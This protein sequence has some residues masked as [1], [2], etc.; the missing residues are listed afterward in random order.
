[1]L[2]TEHKPT[3]I[4]SLDVEATG[5]SPATSSCVMIG[6]VAM[7]DN[8]NPDCTDYVISKKCWCLEEQPG[9]I[10]DKRCWDEFWMNNINVWNYIQEHKQSV[11]IVMKEF[12]EWYYD[13]TTKY[14]GLRFVMKPASYDWQWINA[15]YDQYGPLNKPVLPFSNKC[16]STMIN[17][18]SN[19]KGISNNNIW[20]M[21]KP[22]AD[23]QHTHF[24]DADAHEQGYSYLKLM[25]LFA[26]N[27]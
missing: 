6:V 2:K 11:Q 14:S 15:L 25:W 20:Q 5:T 19:Y 16:L 22:P 13:L 27:T 3:V 24:A 12:S 18:V 23:L 26:S 9:K 17:L 10:I 1:M 7:L 4:I 21:I 8:V